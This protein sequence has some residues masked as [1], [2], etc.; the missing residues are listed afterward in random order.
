LVCCSDLGRKLSQRQG[1]SSKGMDLFCCTERVRTPSQRQKNSC[2]EPPG[3]FSEQRHGEDPEEAPESGHPR[4]EDDA[5][6]ETSATSLGKNSK[7]NSHKNNENGGVPSPLSLGLLDHGT[8]SR[9][10]LNSTLDPVGVLELT[11]DIEDASTESF[12]QLA[13]QIRRQVRASCARGQRRPSRA[14]LLPEDS[15]RLLSLELRPRHGTGL[16]QWLRSELV[17]WDDDRVPL[18]FDAAAIQKEP[19]VAMRL[20]WISKVKQDKK[21]M[22]I[23]FK[24]RGRLDV[25]EEILEHSSP[26]DADACTEALVKCIDLARALQGHS[27]Q[28]PRAS[29]ASDF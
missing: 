15:T 14:S 28:T 21:Y 12:R 23:G 10:S 9:S 7:G 19:L 11:P 26:D 25:C 2:P 18:P 5:H 20:T 6:P 8:G 16:E 29:G 17:I 1:N 4:P 22:R 13:S 27:L 3:F 24:Q